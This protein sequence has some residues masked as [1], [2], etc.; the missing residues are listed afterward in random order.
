MDF[1]SLIQSMNTISEGDVVHK[2]TYG[3]SHGSED[4][5]DQYGH[6]VG[7][8]NKDV[9][10]SKPAEKR[11]RG[12]PKKGADASGEVKKYDWSAFGGSGKDVKLPKWDKSKTTKHSLKEYIEEVETTQLD[13][14]EQL[15]IAPAQQNT[16]VIKQGSKML[17]TVTNPQLAQQIKQAIGQGQMTLNPGTAGPAGMKQEQMAEDEV[18]E[19]GLQA[20]LGNKK[21]GKDGMDALRKAGQEHASEKEMQNIRAKYSNKEEMAEEGGEKWIQKAIKHP[22]A[23]TKKAKAAHMSTSAFAKAH[24]HDKGKTG[25][26]ARLA[27]TLAKMHEEALDQPATMDEK[28]PPGAKAERMVKHIKASYAKDG[29][30]TPKEKAIA[31][32]TTW[33]AHNKGQVEESFKFEDGTILT[34]GAMKDLVTCLLDDLENGPKGYNIRAAQELG[35]KALAQRII[36]KTLQHGDRYKRLAGTLKGQLRDYALEE[37]GFT[38]YDESLEEADTR[39]EVPSKV[40][41]RTHGMDSKPSAFKA[42]ADTP[43][44]RA[45]PTPWK[46]D[47]IQ[48]TTDRAINFISGLGKKSVKESTEDMKDVQLESWEQQLNSLLTEG[49]TVSSS[50]GQQGAPDSL[51]ITATDNDAQSLMGVLRNAGIG[52]F[53]AGEQK[54]EIGYGVAQ[55]GEE[56]FDGTG[57]DP[58]PSPDVVGDGDDMLALI[59]KMSGIETGSEGGQDYEDE[60]GEEEPQNGTLEPADADDEGDKDQDSDEEQTDEGN[61]FSGAVAKAKKDGIQPGEKINV[62]GKEY[63]VKE[64]DME[65]GNMF[66]GNLAKAR[67]Q[68][69]EEADLDGDGD[70]EKVHEGHDETCN[71]C[72]YTMEDCECDHEQMN[73]FAN[74]AGGDAMADTELAK[75]KALLTMGGDL[76]KMKR[77][78][79]VLNPTQVTVRESLNEWKKLSG[80]K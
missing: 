41:L 67:A 6:K 68:G 55:G 11:G 36:D 56:D 18:E 74:D 20:Y 4:V 78:Q 25:K 59:K 22:G 65:E 76:H 71:E 33:A 24:A 42:V 2:G 64:D 23:L 29:K 12:R 80:I 15:T 69:K 3:T 75:L 21:Y 63:P 30:L 32:A 47:P 52:G 46:V 73:E 10:A 37:F 49:I 72:G 48:A 9:A 13:E 60:E 19:S 61:A 66:T 28:A 43:T 58:Q 31:Y 27:Q 35:D 16:Q 50:T 53:G 14:A 5:R 7:K 44:G 39:P 17:G 34:E 57:T 1:R 79:S 38:N 54:P 45:E 8:V 70:M 26:Q 40:A 77:D 51:S 62:G